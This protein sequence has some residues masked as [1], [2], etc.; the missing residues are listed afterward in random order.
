MRKHHDPETLTA[1]EAVG[2]GSFD[3]A[4]RDGEDRA[5]ERFG[6]VGAVDEAQG[7]D[8][9]TERVDFDVFPFHVVSE[10]SQ[11]G[12]QAVED[13]QHQHQIGHAANQRGVALGGQA[14]QFDF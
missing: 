12:L 10:R 1:L 4:P 13:Q 11:P 6:E 7:D 3:L 14:Q 2:R 9:G 5:A 8:P